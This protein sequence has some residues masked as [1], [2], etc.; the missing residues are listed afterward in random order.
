LYT[1]GHIT[2]T[3]G[4]VSARTDENPNEI[5]ITPS[6]IFKGDLRPEMLVRVDLDGNV[7][8]DNGYSASIERHMHCAIYRRR[9]DVDAVVH[10]HAPHA[11]LMAMT[12]TPFL[13][14]SSEAAMLGDLPVVP[15]IG[16]GTPELGEAVAEALGQQGIA[17]L[18]QNHGLVVVGA[19][20]RRAADWTDVVETAAYKL[21]TC[22][23]MGVA[24]ATVPDD[25]VAEMRELGKT[26]G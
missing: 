26:V 19:S 12:G 3:G 9:P 25:I 10:A 14:V 8:S 11:I 16:P 15:F 4:N 23:L 22:R 18:M 17:V 2:P 20:V 6:A 7:L 24:P 1:K 13:P 21:I 5:W